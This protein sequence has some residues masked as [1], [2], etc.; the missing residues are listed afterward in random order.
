LQ[1]RKHDA[2][3]GG[4]FPD[5]ESFEFGLSQMNDAE[6]DRFTTDSTKTG[7]RCVTGHD[8]DIRDVA[9]NGAA[10]RDVAGNDADIR[11]V[12]G[13]DPNIRDVTGNDTDVRDVA[14]QGAAYRDVIESD[15]S[16]EN[17]LVQL[18]DS[19]LNDGHDPLCTPTKQQKIET[20]APETPNI[21]AKFKADIRL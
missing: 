1:T 13:N 15:D 9:G 4:Q 7:H 11:D 2:T 16:F 8:A 14:G 3:D 17:G 5:D 21:S 18:S 20:K 12:T 6:F 19:E 10:Y